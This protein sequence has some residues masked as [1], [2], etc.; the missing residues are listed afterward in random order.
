MGAGHTP[1]IPGGHRHP[2]E[3][4]NLVRQGRAIG[5][6]AA[7]RTAGV[8]VGKDT[9]MLDT[10]TAPR[11]GLLGTQKP[12]TSE[13]SFGDKSPGVACDREEGA[14]RSH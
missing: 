2:H 10:E 9:W 5:A 8:A 4:A 7:P 11:A 1:G 13:L 6:R 12:W 14:T 3:G